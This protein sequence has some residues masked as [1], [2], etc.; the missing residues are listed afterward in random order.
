[1]Q[2]LGLTLAI[3]AAPLMSDEH[4]EPLIKGIVRVHLG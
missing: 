4:R 1:M 3:L 2:L